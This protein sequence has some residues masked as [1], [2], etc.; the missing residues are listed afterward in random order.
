M[1]SSIINPKIMVFLLISLVYFC[2]I[3]KIECSIFH[4]DKSQIKD[5]IL[6][7]IGS[8][9]IATINMIN[10]SS[11][12]EIIK[13]HFLDNIKVTVFIEFLISTYVFPLLAELVIIPIIFLISILI[14]MAK[15]DEKYKDVN[16]LLSITQGLFGLLIVL[17]AV[18]SAIKDYKELIG[19]AS[20]I[21]FINPIYLMIMYFPI[22]YCWLLYVIY[23]T[24]FIK[25]SAIFKNTN[26]PQLGRRL[27]IEIVKLCRLNYTL[28]KDVDSQKYYFW[29]LIDSQEKLN[30]FISANKKRVVMKEDFV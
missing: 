9:I 21:S 10:L 5:A 1:I 12:R 19:E 25:I 26:N 17:Y 2:C 16:R 28:I 20:I 23:E 6:W 13:K 18:F 29:H 30:D 7:F 24:V 11:S 3:L 15:M 4:L 22:M 14:A 8:G 27:K